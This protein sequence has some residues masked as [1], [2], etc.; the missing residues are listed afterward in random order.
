MIRIYYFARE[1][2]P[3]ETRF[4]QSPASYTL[5]YRSFRLEA[6]ARAFAQAC[7]DDTSGDCMIHSMS[8][9]YVANL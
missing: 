6:R 5:K 8:L 2:N 9:D 1:T 7:Y 3:C 4:P